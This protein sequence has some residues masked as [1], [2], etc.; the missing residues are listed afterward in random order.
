[1]NPDAVV[2]GVDH[3]S[4]SQTAVA[5]AANRALR[6]GSHL[7]LV[8]VVDPSLPGE[9]AGNARI[10]ADLAL[11]VSYLKD[12]APGL[13]YSIELERGDPITELARLGSHGALLVIGTH[14]TGYVQG[15]V[16]GSL[17]I[18]LAA[19]SVAPLAVIPAR[20]SLHPTGVVVGIDL[21][22]AGISAIRFAAIEAA[23]LGEDLT[24]V[25]AHGTP[26]EEQG[27]G[28]AEIG[29]LARDIVRTAAPNTDIRVR[30]VNRGAA[31]A[32]ID[33]AASAG[34]LV[35]GSSRRHRPGAGALGPVSFDVLVNIPTPTI[36]VHPPVG[37]HTPF[38]SRRRASAAAPPQ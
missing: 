1:M 31:E 15:R 37:S 22:S 28:G 36:V 23:A 35:V 19:V 20:S 33:I 10:D 12:N 30:T 18:R 27:D 25:Y 32:L 17:S 6:T 8:H 2:V 11:T 14:K 21:T 3:S 13:E 16:F 29:A 34:L 7:V 26:S 5:W 38:I 9:Y 4:A 24:L